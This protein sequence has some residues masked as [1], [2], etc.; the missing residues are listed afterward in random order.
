VIVRRIIG[1]PDD[2]WFASQKMWGG[3][4]WVHDFKVKNIALSW[5]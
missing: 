3:E 4:A 2:M 1:C 5:K